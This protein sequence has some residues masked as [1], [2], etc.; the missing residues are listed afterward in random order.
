MAKNVLSTGFMVEPAIPAPNVRTNGGRVVHVGCFTRPWYSG[1]Y[2]VAASCHETTPQCWTFT[3]T[4]DPVTCAHCRA[5]MQRAGLPRAGVTQPVAVT[6]AQFRL[7]VELEDR[8]RIPY[9][10][11]RLRPPSG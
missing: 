4:S 6:R 8:V 3:A 2:K 1:L 7:A 10:V 11:P 5:R 9:S